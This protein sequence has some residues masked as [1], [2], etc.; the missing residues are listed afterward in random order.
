MDHRTA[1]Y[2][3][4]PVTSEHREKQMPQ[5]SLARRAVFAA[6][7][8]LVALTLVALAPIT[9]ASG[10]PATIRDVGGD[11]TIDESQPGQQVRPGQKSVDILTFT[12]RHQHKRVWLSFRLRDLQRVQVMNGQTHVFQI[13]LRSNR[14]QTDVDITLD[15]RR[16]HGVIEID[17]AP[18]SE[19]DGARR[20]VSYQRDL[21]AISIPRACLGGPRWIQASTFVWSTP[22]DSVPWQLTDVAGLNGRRET[23]P[24]PFTPRLHRG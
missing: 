20:S 10:E 19:C 23:G 14:R 12:A 3:P 15:R 16:P 7:L 18:T 17:G 21:V 6:T 9:A 1:Q 8:T 2:R 4:A 13:Q 11:V 5:N 24:A 22:G